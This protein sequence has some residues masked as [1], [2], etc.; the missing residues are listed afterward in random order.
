M[1]PK[2]PEM[3]PRKVLSFNLFD[4]NLPKNIFFKRFG[5]LLKYSKF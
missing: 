1:L 5:K 4:R 2:F 3:F